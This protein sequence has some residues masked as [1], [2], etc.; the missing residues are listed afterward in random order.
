MPAISSLISTME[1]DFMLLPRKP[2]KFF[3]CQ[4]PGSNK[5]CRNLLQMFSVSQREAPGSMSIGGARIKTI[6]LY[7][8]CMI[9]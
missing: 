5:S 6:N 7:R 2:E 8:D 4:S 1:P 9:I 3:Q